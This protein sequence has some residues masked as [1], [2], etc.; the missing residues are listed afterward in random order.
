MRAHLVQAH[1]DEDQRV[2]DA[3][4][5]QLAVVADEKRGGRDRERVLHQPGVAVPGL[6][7]EER[8][9]DREDQRSGR[10]GTCDAE[11]SRHAQPDRSAATGRSSSGRSAAACRAAG[12]ARATG[13]SFGLTASRPANTP[14]A[15]IWPLPPIRKRMVSAPREMSPRPGASNRSISAR[16]SASRRSAGWHRLRCPSSRTAVHHLRGMVPSVQ[17][18]VEQLAVAVQFLAHAGKEYRSRLRRRAAAPESQARP[19]PPPKT[20]ARPA[21]VQVRQ[22]RPR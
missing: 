9:P 8:P 5:Q 16:L 20:S 17:G 1:E 18:A 10:A 22:G 2:R 15:T 21:A 11:C 19:R 3:R 12:S 13:A 6:D 7:G 14:S 4:E